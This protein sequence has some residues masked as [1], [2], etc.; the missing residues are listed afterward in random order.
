MR[1]VMMYLTL[2]APFL[3]P[4]APVVT[5]V[6]TD[7]AFQLPDSIPSGVTTFHF[8]NAGTQPHELVLVKIASGHTLADVL[9]AAQKDGP[10]PPWMTQTGG[11][12]AVLPGGDARVTLRLRPGQYALLCGV[13]GKDGVPHL[14]KGMIKTLTV[15]PGTSTAS[16]PTSDVTITMV[17]FD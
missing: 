9:Q 13:P 1:L 2:L 8:K 16:E 10:N 14:M 6:A 3:A 11:P 7:Y 12:G 4:R 5:V 15:T 17:D